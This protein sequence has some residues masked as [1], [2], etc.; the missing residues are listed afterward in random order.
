MICYSPLKIIILQENHKQQSP[1]SLRLRGFVV[2]KNLQELNY[3]LWSS[4]LRFLARPAAVPLSA[5]GFAWP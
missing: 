3:L 5:M 1:G 2:R 4:T